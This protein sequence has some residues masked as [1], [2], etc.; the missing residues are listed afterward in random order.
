MLW[1]LSDHAVPVD[2][3][4]VLIRLGNRTIRARYRAATGEFIVRR[5]SESISS[6]V[7]WTSYT[8]PFI[9]FLFG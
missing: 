6:R 7:K 3:S 1:Y 5:T 2:G 4:Q 9:R 8:T